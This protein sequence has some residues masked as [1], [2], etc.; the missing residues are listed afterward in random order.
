[1]KQPQREIYILLADLIN[2]GIAPFC[3]YGSPEDFGSICEEPEGYYACE[4]PLEIN[5]ELFTKGDCMPC[6]EPCSDC[7]GFR[8]EYSLNDIVDIVGII[9]ANSWDRWQ[10]TKP[11]KDNPQIIVSGISMR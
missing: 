5:R 10:F 3:K 4:H 8:P 9:L 11:T 1:M 7:W 6:E 2:S